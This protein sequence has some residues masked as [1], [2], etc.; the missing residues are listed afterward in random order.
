MEIVPRNS[1]EYVKEIKH[2]EGY[3]HE[4]HGGYGHDDHGGGGYGHVD[5]SEGGYGHESHGGG[6]GHDD[7]GGGG[8]DHDVHDDHSGS[9]G[10][11][12]TGV[13]V[14]HHDRKADTINEPVYMPGNQNNYP[15]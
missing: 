7:H 2:E 4:E 8:Y 14:D 5:N 15:K 12:G 1:C 6:Y 13:Y 11:K 3:G 9:G 10:E